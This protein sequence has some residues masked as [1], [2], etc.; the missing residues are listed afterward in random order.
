MKVDY[1]LFSPETQV[2]IARCREAVNNDTA[3]I[4]QLRAA[5]EKMR[6]ERTSAIQAA[7]ASAKKGGTRAPRAT[8][9][10]RV[11]SVDVNKAMEDF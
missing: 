5:I 7:A 4:E 11:A 8:K 3:T 6:G 9:E 10:E 2:E 1:T